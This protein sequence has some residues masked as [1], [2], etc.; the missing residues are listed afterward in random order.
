[1][2]ASR[3]SR[4]LLR[5]YPPA[6]QA[7]YG[8]ELEALIV[9][10]SGGERVPWRVGFDVVLA[11]GRERLR[12]TWPGNGAAPSERARGGALLVL[13]AWTLFVVAGAGAQKASE[14]WQAVTPAASRDL[15]ATALDVL[16]VM[17]TGAGVL[18][19]I[20]ITATLPALAT[21]LRGGGWPAIR[22]RVLVA[23]LLSGA[24]IAATVALVI[25]A[26]GLTDRQRAGHDTAYEIAFL[27][28]ALLGIAGLSAWTAAAITTA[29]KLR[30][31]VATL[32]L[33]ARLACAVT[34]AMGLM[35]AA[36]AVW[37]AALADAAPWFLAGRRV[38]EAASPVAPQL[39]AVTA[40]MALATL[41][42]AAGAQRA[43]RAVP[44]L[45]DQ[46]TSCGR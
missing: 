25:W 35:T 23:A 26:H 3:T 38:G 20:G 9:E 30:L 32:A 39:V 15:P 41:L 24:A 11:G 34:V 44:V 45:A 46:S 37:W 31:S 40:L 33:Q 10:S 36:T 12:T 18:V 43:I 14:H 22:R 5:C 42:G 2:S 1:M 8:E 4:L 7:R 17:A 28:W 27:A 29:R 6:W 19:A 21:F 13:C 16:V